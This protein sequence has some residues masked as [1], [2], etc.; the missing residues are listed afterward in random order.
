MRENAKLENVRQPKQSS[1]KVWKKFGSQ[2]RVR[3]KFE[4]SSKKVRQPKQSSK[5]V[6]KKF[7]S[8][9]RVRKKFEKNGPF[10]MLGWYHNVQS[11]YV[12]FAFVLFPYF[13]RTLFWLPNSVRILCVSRKSHSYLLSG[14][15]SNI[16]R[17]GI[18]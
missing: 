6:R 2:G 9:S 14:G 7:G 10:F 18:F 15:I 16:F 4:K 17:T 3:K 1:K 13:F 5:K 12:V 11:S 8:Q